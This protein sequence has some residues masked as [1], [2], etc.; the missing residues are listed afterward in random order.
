MQSCVNL[1]NMPVDYSAHPSINVAMPCASILPCTHHSLLPLTVLI[2]LSDNVDL[3][4]WT[5]LFYMGQ[6]AYPLIIFRY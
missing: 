6:Q 4:Y 3:P 5:E 2:L 1:V